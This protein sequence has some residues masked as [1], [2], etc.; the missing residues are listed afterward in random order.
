MDPIRATNEA[1]TYNT[2][3]TSTLQKSNRC[4]KRK[5]TLPI[6]PQ[7]HQAF[8]KESVFVS[9]KRKENIFC[10]TSVLFPSLLRTITCFYLQTR[11]FRCTCDYPQHYPQLYVHSTKELIKRRLIQN[12]NIPAGAT[13]REFELLKIG[14]LNFRL[15]SSPPPP[16]QNCVQMFHSTQISIQESL[17]VQQM[18]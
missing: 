14:N 6:R 18:L 17:S 8:P 1:I 12:F 11:T 15:P 13:P 16:G 10:H 7:P 3:T 5:N 2:V 4:E 9:N